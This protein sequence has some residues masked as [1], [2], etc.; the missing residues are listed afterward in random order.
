MKMILR[1]IR[2]TGLDRIIGK[3]GFKG[4]WLLYGPPLSSGLSL[5]SDKI[6]QDNLK[7]TLKSLELSAGFQNG[8]YLSMLQVVID[9]SA[10]VWQEK[11]NPGVNEGVG[12]DLRDTASA[13]T[14]WEKP[15][16]K[17][18]LLICLRACTDTGLGQARQ[19]LSYIVK[20]PIE[21][22][23]RPCLLWTSI[24]FFESSQ[25]QC[26]RNRNHWCVC[27]KHSFNSLLWKTQ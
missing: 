27:A 19:R 4:T 5:D 17:G 7:R 11:E 8:W 13:S 26:L 1:A 24:S 3:S 23:N 14:H 16:V 10:S 25:T 21:V 12:Q 22:S 20:E 9:F 18:C 6:V 15:R 2:K